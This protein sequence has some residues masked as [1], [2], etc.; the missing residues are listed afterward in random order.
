MIFQT[1]FNPMNEINVLFIHSFRLLLLI[2]IIMRTTIHL[3]AIPSC[4]RTHSR[5]SILFIFLNCPHLNLILIKFLNIAFQVTWSAS[6]VERL[7]PPSLPSSTVQIVMSSVMKELMEPVSQSR[8]FT[9]HSTRE[10]LWI[11]V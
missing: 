7:K 8:G 5:V 6:S 9:F 2:T 4:H 10:I 1:Q 3:S 11:S